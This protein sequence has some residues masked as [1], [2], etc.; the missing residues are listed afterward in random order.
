MA[1]PRSCSA[2]AAWCQGH[3]GS[4]LPACLGHEP[5][6][7]FLFARSGLPLPPSCS[8]HI[9]LHLDTPPQR[10]T[11]SACWPARPECCQSLPAGLCN[12]QAHRQ[13][14]RPQCAGQQESLI[15]VA[16][17]VVT[18]SFWHLSSHTMRGQ[19]HAS[20]AASR[21]ACHGPRTLERKDA[22]IG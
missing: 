1:L 11:G 12:C 21:A 4:C 15:R 6:P 5:L 14:L 7:R 9:P 20:S 2:G 18:T 22:R 13:R 8:K 16:S 19:W 17:T 3:A 10:L